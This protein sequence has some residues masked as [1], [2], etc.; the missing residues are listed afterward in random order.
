MTRVAIVGAGPAG[1]FAAHEL[2]QEG[3]EVAV[4][5]MGKDVSS[6]T[7]TDAFDLLH[8]MGGSGTFSDGKINFHPEV[9]GDLYEFL[10]R[11]DAWALVTHIEE[12]LRGYGVEVIPT[13]DDRTLDLEKRAAK[14]GFRFLPI[15]QAHIG[16]D[17]LTE[18][19]ERFY[20]D[21]RDAG[22][23]FRFNTR[24]TDIVSEQGRIQGLL[25]EDDSTIPADCVLLAPGRVGN[26][27]MQDL[28]VRHGLKVSHN[29][30]DVG[31]RV[32]V[33]AIV[34]EEIIEI[35]YDPKFYVRAPTYDDRVRT[36]CVSPH[37]FVVKEVYHDEGV[38]GVNG[39]ALRDKQSENT[40]FALLVSIRLT[41]PVESTTAYGLAIA[42]LATTIGGGKPTLQSLGDL[43]RHRR[44]T[45][46]RLQ[47]SPGDVVPTLTDVTPGDISMALPHRVVTDLEEALEILA[48]VIPGL[49]ADRTLLY[50][51]ELKRYATRPHTDK[52]LKTEID[53][54]Y[55][56]GDGAGVARGIGGSAATGIIA[57]RGIVATST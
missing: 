54:L 23:R 48:G 9:G 55:I 8:G 18:M 12:I 2:V 38:V 37:G 17:H 20:A 36:F 5:D 40:N 45:W 46:G 49:D 41:E 11:D 57:A 15:R 47:K 34:M 51:L 43:R 35:C 42:Q 7:R 33:P 3:I 50:A 44:S 27:W 6:R 31:V 14:C 22:V 13:D 56:A 28:A 26:T 16:S 30:V 39:H 1:L 21:L 24:V 25:L 4:I 29:P 10:P 32:E 52:S 19:M 53:G